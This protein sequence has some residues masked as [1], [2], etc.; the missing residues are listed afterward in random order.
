MSENILCVG[1]INW[2]IGLQTSEIP[3]PDH[4]EKLENVHRKPGGSATNTAM[5][6]SGLNKNAAIAGSTGNDEKAEQ[7]KQI[8]EYIGLNHYLNENQKTTVI[9]AILTNNNAPRYLYKEDS[10]GTFS[11]DIIPST[12]WNTFDHLHI[13]SFNKTIS[14]SFVEKAIDKNMT[15]SFNPSHKF[16]STTYPEIVHNSNIIVL[17]DKEMNILENR[18]D[19]SELAKDTRIVCTHG[20]EG[21]TAYYQNSE[22]KH[23][24]F[25]VDNVQDTIGAGDSFIAG[26]LSKWTENNSLKNCLTYGNAVAAASVETQGAP[27]KISLEKI[28]Q[29]I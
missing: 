6:L 2:D 24:G 22:T 15:I 1:F 17:N 29:Y 11:T 14:K 20:S 16:K 19:I 7:I 3:S 9:Y 10:I 8:F 26:F 25:S 23:N 27:N 12:K 4:S 28:N 18:Y 21:C 5:V 13:T